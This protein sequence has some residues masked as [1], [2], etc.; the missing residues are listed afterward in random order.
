MKV[1]KMTFSHKQRLKKFVTS[2]LDLQELADLTYK[3]LKVVL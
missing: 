1:E 2:K 3:E